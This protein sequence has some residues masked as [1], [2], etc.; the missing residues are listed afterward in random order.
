MSLPSRRLVDQVL[1]AKGPCLGAVF[2][3]YTFDPIYFEDHV[4][5]SLLQLAGDPAED[6]ARYLA[7][8]RSALREIPVA[9]FVDAGVR[10]GGRRLPYDL[11]LHRKRTFHPKVYLVLFEEEAR[12]AVGSG[13][14]TRPGL[15]NNAELFFHRALRYDEPA[16]AAMLRAV[17][18]F[19]E[20]CAALASGGGTQL[21][22]VRELL[23]ARMAGTRPLAAGAPIDAVF[24]SSF[25][26]AGLQALS[27]ALPADATLERIG[28]LSPFYERDDLEA[29][30]EQEG[31]TS[32][33]AQLMA[34]RPGSR[35]RLELGVPWDDAAVTAPSR[36][37]SPTLR[38]GLWAW[39]R[40]QQ[41][42]DEQVERLD[43]LEI[44]Q[45]HARRVDVRGVDGTVQRLERERLEQAIAE[46]KLWP[47][48]PPTVLAP[49][50]ILERIA[51][52]H[53]VQLWLHPT[54]TLSPE[55]KTARRPLHA[56]LF[57]LTVSRRGKSWTY[58][59]LGSANASRAAMLRTV[60]EGGNV[61]AGILLRLDGEVGL[62]QLVPGLVACAFDSATFQER[63]Y[64]PVDLD[65]S[66]CI[67]EAVHHADARTLTIRWARDEVAALGAWRLRYLD[68]LCC[69]G[70]GVPA[71][72][73]VV[74]DF[75]LSGSSA[76][77]T[78]EAGGGSWSVP[79]RVAD[80]ALLPIHP[81]MPALE[82]AALLA[83][84]GGR[85]GHERMT[86]I[87]ERRGGAGLSAM[88]A[89][90]FGEGFGPADVF[91]AWW[92]LGRELSSAPT[93]A[94]FRARL[95]GATGAKV[96]WRALVAT[97]G[98]PTEAAS[99]EVAGREATTTPSTGPTTE[100]TLASLSREEVWI[101]GCELVRELQR[102][103]LTAGPDRRA[104]QRLRDAL[105][106]EISAE[107]PSLAPPVEAS[108]LGAVQRFYGVGGGS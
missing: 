4:L 57:T 94:A 15:E 20:R 96:V 90:I 6:S 33:L 67:D 42:D 27:E 45:V 64:P 10:Q 71:E 87:Y 36:P 65:L 100:P 75:E 79:I 24:V 29:A 18:A 26:R 89:A 3:S 86:T 82:L 22:Q 61:E 77:L 101:Y 95:L 83:L 106:A 19:F 102:L 44:Q 14:L 11:H 103:E 99:E 69:E 32:V 40:Q 74:S 66:A 84:L 108:W 76:E 46:A 41:R 35:P 85:A 23:A 55:G 21:A 52:E 28:V 1:S 17:D 16:A 34:L 43:H 13:N 53:A 107:L 48:E 38:P 62:P 63:A 47:V 58:A 60:A 88:L 7:E 93:L 9:C 59:L 81:G 104:C 8:A 72:A 73:T 37:T 49:K 56:K 98:A 70:D 92:G 12:L 97:C 5:R 25:E 54:V 51:A 2:C 80:L 31:L 78:L 30:D 105:V 39:R 91:K 50:N 68:R